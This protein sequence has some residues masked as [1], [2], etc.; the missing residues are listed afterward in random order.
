MRGIEK[1]QP[2]AA[3]CTGALQDSGVLV[4]CVYIHRAHLQQ[5]DQLWINIL[6]L[7][8]HAAVWKYIWKRFH[9]RRI[10]ETFWRKRHDALFY[11]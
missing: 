8:L 5:L 3:L 9:T 11:L 7:Q 2:A 10:Y 1:G 4:I 6:Q